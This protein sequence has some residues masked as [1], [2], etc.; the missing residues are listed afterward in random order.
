VASIPTLKLRGGEVVP[1][2]GMGTWHMGEHAL[3]RPRE[4]AALRLGLDMAMNLIDTA[5]MY[6]EG[7]AESVVGEAIRGWREGVFVVTKFYPHHAARRK[8]IAACDNSLK[9][10]GGETIDLYLL[11]W[12]GTVPLEETVD[13]LEELV[14]EGK[15]QRWGVSNFDVADMEEL[16]AVPGGDRVAAN[17]VLY[18]LARRGIE[19]DL[20]PWCAQR[21]IPLM[22]YSPLDEGR[23]IRHPALT[24]VARRLGVDP[25][26]VALAWLLRNPRV[27]AIPKAST[28][29]HVGANRA[30]ADILL[31]AEALAH[32]EQAFPPPRRK[33]PLEML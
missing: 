24:A 15:I 9:Q 32:L 1:R 10:L 13:T 3:D 19:Y 26:Q 17:Q 27:I 21:D 6:G 4:I 23:L 25:G 22:A 16:V 8:L 29:E 7:G 31:D 5:E 11:H 28:P 18:N 20:V 33:H 2:L 30:A 14:R 12:R